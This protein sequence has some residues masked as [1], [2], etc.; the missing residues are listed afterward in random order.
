[1]A[2]SFLVSSILVAIAFIHVPTTYDPRWPG[3]ASILFWPLFPALGAFAVW[4]FS[5]VLFSVFVGLAKAATQYGGTKSDEV[6][7]SRTGTSSTYPNYGL[8]VPASLAINT[9]VTGHL[10]KA[11]GMKL[12]V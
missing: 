4:M 7:S 9:V 1:M 5:M 3:F 12:L 2:F 11:A 10:L 6:N 8:S